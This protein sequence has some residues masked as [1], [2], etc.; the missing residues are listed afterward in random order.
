MRVAQIGFLLFFGM[1][2]AGWYRDHP[3]AVVAMAVLV[4][5]GLL[6][7]LLRRGPRRA[8]VVADAIVSGLAAAT[9]TWITPAESRGDPASVVFV[10]VLTVVVGAAFSHSR[11]LFV[12]ILATL[13]VAQLASAVGHRPQVFASTAIMVVVAV[14]VRRAVDRLRRVAIEADR[15]RRAAAARRRRLLVAEGRERDTREQER[16]LHDTILNTLTGLGM[17]VDQPV[18]LLRRQCD[19]SVRV[20]EEQLAGRAEPGVGVLER[21]AQVV[22]AA[23]V[24]GLRVTL[25]RVP[26]TAQAGTARPGAAE[27][28]GDESVGD[29]SVGD[30]A[31]GEGPGGD[32][33]ALIPDEVATAVAAAAGEALR[34]V[35]SHAGVA[36]ARVEVALN[37][38]DLCVRVVDEGRGFQPE[39]DAAGGQRLGLRNSIVARMWAAGG[40]AEIWSRPGRGTQVTL[41]WEAPPA[42]PAEALAAAPLAE[43]LTIAARR[44]F[45]VAVVVGWLAALV[46]VI[47]HR[48]QTRSFAAGLAV[49]LV[50]AV[51][52]AVT[53]RV[54]ARRALRR[55]EALGVLLVAIAS[56]V[57]GA[58]NTVE[59]PGHLV[60]SWGT[61]M[62]NPLLV[63]LAVLTRRAR[64]RYA[65]AALAAVAM[66][67]IVLG[68]GG[69][70]NELVMARL[71]AAIY[72]LVILQLLVTMFGPVLRASAQ[73]RAR[74]ADLDVELVSRRVLGRA[75]RRDRQLRLK[76]LDARFLPLLR[77][78]AAGRLDPADPDVRAQCTARA[79]ALRRDLTGAGPAALRRLTGPIEEAEA[80][81]I[82]VTVQTVGELMVIPEAVRGEFLARISA[83][84]SAVRHGPVLLTA[85]VDD[86]GA[87]VYLTYPARS[88]ARPPAERAAAV[89]SAA[90]TSPAEAAVGRRGG[91][92]PTRRAATLADFGRTGEFGPGG[93][94]LVRGGGTIG[95]GVVC[96]EMHWSAAEAVGDAPPAPRQPGQP[97]ETGRPAGRTLAAAGAGG[98]GG[99]DA[100]IAIAGLRGSGRS[101]E[102]VRQSSPD[103]TAGWRRRAPRG[104]R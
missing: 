66:A 15:Q 91:G 55:G 103:R 46:P 44:A 47:L 92:R 67:A 63:A 32:P 97:V 53:A 65:A 87:N 62:V 49:W 29:E 51:V 69:W 43:Q 28:V 90:A 78:I 95:D 77:D 30:E 42:E 10:V 2:W 9:T 14:L 45:A 88:A 41:S 27:S 80:R 57:A 64:E 60:V 8:Y 23:S 96:V 102:D 93:S 94:G 34:N 26:P 13:A 24:D 11:R 37:P 20:V 85:Y 18:E 16:L 70:G 73:Q 81:G 58:V 83:V 1:V 36:H 68:L 98:S 54:V 99:P 59:L 100:L 72:A 84:L 61:T 4:A 35:R 75:V 74:A 3:I 101:G 22:S 56:A 7:A 17:S 52:I 19:H 48:D 5:W 38:G 86:S 33:A 39:L 79:R 82:A 40:R 25:V 12:A 89:S 31:V 71:G 50:T 104:A 76:E 21:L 6:L